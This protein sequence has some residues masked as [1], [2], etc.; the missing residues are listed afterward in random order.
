MYLQIINIYLDLLVSNRP[1]II[2]LDSCI[3]QSE[4]DTTLSLRHL[5]K[6]VD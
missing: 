6:K 1:E 2:L 3:A 5:Y 4:D